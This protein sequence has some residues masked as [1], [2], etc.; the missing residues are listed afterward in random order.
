[1]LYDTTFRSPMLYDTTFRSSIL[2]DTTVGLPKL[3]DTTFG[4]LEKRNKLRVFFL[5]RPYSTRYLGQHLSASTIM[6]ITP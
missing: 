5:E 4:Q 2:Y 3:Y 6:K 1:M